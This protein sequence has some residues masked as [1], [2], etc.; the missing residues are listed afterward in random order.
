MLNLGGLIL[1]GLIVGEVVSLAK[2]NKQGKRIAKLE[3]ETGG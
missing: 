3:Q 2:L 1:I